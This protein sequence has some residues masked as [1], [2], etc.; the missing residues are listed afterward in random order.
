[1]IPEK[2]HLVRAGRVTRPMTLKLALMA[3]G[4]ATFAVSGAQAQF[5]TGGYTSASTPQARA[6]QMDALKKRQQAEGII[7]LN[8]P[9]EP[10]P[11]LQLFAAVSLAETFTSNASG[12]NGSNRYDFY[13]QPGLQLGAVEQSR[14]LT[15][16]VN[17]A[18]TYQYYARNHDLDQFINNLTANANA[19]L[20]EQTL[21]LDAQASAAPELLSRAGSLTASDGTPTK[22]NY[23]NTYAYAVRPTLIHQFGSVVETD[24]WA[25]ESGVYFTTPSSAST[26]PLPGFYVP[27]TNSN[28]TQI[29][30]RIA[31][32]S[33]FMRLNWSLNA[34]AA[35]TYQEHH[36]WQKVRS[37]SANLSYNLSTDFS[38]IATGGYQTYH[39]SFFLT[40]DLDGPILLGGF[41]FTPDPNFYFY[42][43]A[44]SQ[45]NFPTYIGQLVWNI[46][47]LTSFSANATDQIQTPQQQ[48]VS[49]LQS[50][51]PGGTTGTG[52]GTPS[53]PPPAG[54]VNPG[55]SDF[56][57]N[58][59][60][61]DNSVY[62]YRN[63]TATLTHS[64]PR[65]QYTLSAYAYLRD[66]LDS[67][68]T[69]PF[70]NKH[71]ENFGLTA[72]VTHSLRRD[73]SANV[74]FSASRANEFNGH[75][76]IFEGMAG[77]QYR[78]SETLSFYGNTSIVNRQS[79]GLVGFN[80]GNATDVRVTVG[81]SKAF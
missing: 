33:D 81:V 39:S 69:L 36:Q 49:T 32:L 19:E 7:D 63:F 2:L 73:L 40:K 50:G 53:T 24:L 74:A 23:R 61:L 21:F 14:R 45:N 62:R 75:D 16:A 46:T 35:D 17:Y 13:T 11:E 56:F 30:A 31:S 77:L 68:S 43:Q 15:A 29:G 1:M 34:S 6:Q 52:G 37:A 18:L 12:S 51:A 59:L 25:G 71:N 76:R 65:T 3:F 67:I 38:L 20:L 80:N 42:A 55:S 22:N 70:L 41:Q 48:L 44:G 8:A 58:G 72:G 66:R 9:T 28:T 26:T 78:A 64:L 60:S 27:P 57:G 10:I 4:L 54:D 5:D 79:T 47:P